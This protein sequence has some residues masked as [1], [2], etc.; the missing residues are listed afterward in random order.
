MQKN[1]RDYIDD[2]YD[3]LDHPYTKKI[4]KRQIRIL[5]QYFL[6]NILTEMVHHNNIHIVD[7]FSINIDKGFIFN[8]NIKLTD[9]YYNYKN[10]DI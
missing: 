2:V 1:L 6:N 10:R 5:L 8:K 4:T 9:I 7:K 3:S